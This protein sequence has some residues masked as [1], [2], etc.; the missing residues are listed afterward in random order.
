M[1]LSVPFFY[2][3]RQGWPSEPGSSGGNT[4]E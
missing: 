2:M 3:L 4:S 1:R